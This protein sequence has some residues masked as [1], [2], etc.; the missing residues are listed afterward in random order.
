MMGSVSAQVK[1]GEMSRYSTPELHQNTEA[2]DR[3]K[4]EDCI[5]AQGRSAVSHIIRSKTPSWDKEH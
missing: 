1:D 5:E 3:R 4:Y 2:D